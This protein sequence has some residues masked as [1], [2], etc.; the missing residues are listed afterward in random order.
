MRPLLLL[1]ALVLAV[2]GQLVDAQESRPNVVLILSDDQGWPDY[3]F[4]GHEAIETPNL[5]RLAARSVLFRRGYVPSPLCRPSLASIVTGLYPHQHGVCSNDVDSARRAESD[6]PVRAQFHKHPSLVRSLVDSGYLAFQSGKWWEGSYRDGGFTHGMTLGDPARGG[7]HGDRGLKIGRDGMQPIT[8]FIDDAVERRRPFFV[9]YAPFLPHTPHTPP[10]ALLEKYTA[11]E[12]PANAAKYYAMCDWFDQTCGTLLDHLDTAGVAENTLVLYVCDNGWAPLDA[13]AENPPG[14]WNDYAPRSKGSPF[15]RGIRTPLMI[16][17]PGRIDPA[18]SPDLAT[19]LDL[20][21][22]TLKACGLEPPAGLPGIDLLDPAAR[23]GRGAVFG[24][25]WSIHNSTPGDPM[26]TLQY[27]WCVTRR[28]K[29]LV[30]HHGIDTTRYRT[31]HEWDR[32]AVRLYEVAVDPNE[33]DNQAEVFP[34]T[35]Q[36]L[37]AKIDAVLPAP[38]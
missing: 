28:W 19:T 6:A 31:V 29:L 3:G 35:V 34:E 32:E 22:T 30:R 13:G 12:R 17:W 24:G 36:A 1:V 11:P 20:M 14:W 27:R 26:A 2:N 37:T 9:W 7:R 33:Q 21:P 38:E 16:S 4:M 10:Q 5:D 15:E 23:A 8:E 18:D 25:A